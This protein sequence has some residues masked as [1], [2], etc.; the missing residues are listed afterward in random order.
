MS[1]KAAGSLKCATCHLWKKENTNPLPDNLVVEENRLVLVAKLSGKR[2]PVPQAEDP[3]HEK[4]G[5]EIE[6]QVCH[7]QWGFSDETTHLMRSDA[8]DYDAWERLIVQSSSEVENLL[9]NNLSF[10]REEIE[11]VM[12]DSIT[13]RQFPGVWYKG[14]TQRRWEQIHIKRDTDGVIKVFRPILDLRVSY[15]NNDEEV[16]F[17]SESGFGPVMVPYTPHTTGPAGLFYR[18]RFADLTDKTTD[19]PSRP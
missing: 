16:I 11:P 3:V 5:K 14:Y 15:L 8:E 4:Y 12:K 1:G 13:G 9:R 7:A 17:D 19:L 2:H 6:C 10:D 18:N